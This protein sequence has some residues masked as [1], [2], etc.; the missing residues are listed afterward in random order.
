LSLSSENLVSNFAFTF[1]LYRY[2]SVVNRASV[3]RA[4]RGPKGGVK[5]TW[6]SWVGSPEEDFGAFG[7]EAEVVVQPG[8]KGA[9]Y[10]RWEGERPPPR[11]VGVGGGGGA[12]AGGARAAQQQQRQ[13]Q[14][15]R[16][17]VGHWGS[18]GDENEDDGD[19]PRTFYVICRGKDTKTGGGGGG[20]DSS[21]AA[22]AFG[23]RGST[24]GRGGGGTGSCQSSSSSSGGGGGGGGGGKGEPLPAPPPPARPPES[25]FPPPSSS[26]HPPRLLFHRPLL[27]ADKSVLAL[28][29]DAEVTA[30]LPGL[31]DISESKLRGL[32]EAHREDLSTPAGAAPKSAMVDVVLKDTGAF[33]G[34]T[35]GRPYQSK[36]S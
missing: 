10:G 16:G 17:S 4:K 18:D 20:A 11:R 34:V 35:V 28:F 8:E 36:C 26:R 19:L 13:Q 3:A 24:S 12:G 29:R 2:T 25:V 32:R 6:Q 7:W 1:N 5:A 22:A 30:H 21:S 33:V 14:Q 31:R 9:D 23:G 15:Q 27:R